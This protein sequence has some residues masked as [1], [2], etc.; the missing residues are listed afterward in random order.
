MPNLST[1]SDWMVFLLGVITYSYR[2]Y[3]HKEK[4]KVKAVEYFEKADEMNN[5]DAAYNLG[6]M[7]HIGDYPGEKR[8]IVSHDSFFV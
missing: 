6:H 2:Y 3:I 4:N 7:Y 8:N 5:V 1:D